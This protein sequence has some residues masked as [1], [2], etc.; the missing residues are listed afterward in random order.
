MKNKRRLYLAVTA[1]VAAA[2]ASFT[3]YDPDAALEVLEG[4]V[5]IL[6]PAGEEIPVEAPVPEEGG[7]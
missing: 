7:G 2:V 5:D 6:A 1:L 4:V 3:A